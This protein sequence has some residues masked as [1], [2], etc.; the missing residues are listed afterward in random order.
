MIVRRPLSEMAMVAQEVGK[1]GPNGRHITVEA[2]WKYNRA[3]MG[4]V[5]SKLTGGDRP[6]NCAVDEGSNESQKNGKFELHDS[7]ESAG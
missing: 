1:Y 5:S 3:G 4:G 6:H 7:R 2:G